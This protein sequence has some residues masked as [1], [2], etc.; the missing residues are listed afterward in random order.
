MRTNESELMED[1][2]FLK[3]ACGDG[4][5]TTRARWRERWRKEAGGVVATSPVLPLCSPN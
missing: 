5:G 2:M 3:Q 1:E 4:E